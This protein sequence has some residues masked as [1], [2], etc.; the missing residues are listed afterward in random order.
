M[1]YLT[2]NVEIVRRRG[3]RVPI[4]RG[5]ADKPKRLYPGRAERRLS[6]VSGAVSTG[7]HVIVLNSLLLSSAAD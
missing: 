4:R 5:A 3:W 7:I 1:M 6:T 2:A